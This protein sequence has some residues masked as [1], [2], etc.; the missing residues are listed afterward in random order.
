MSW[1]NG[2]IGSLLAAEQVK[3]GRIGP[4]P[5]QALVA[6]ARHNQPAADQP[7]PREITLATPVTAWDTSQVL[8]TG[9]GRLY[10]VRVENMSADI[11]FAFF[12]DS[13]IAQVIAAVRVPAAITAGT[14]ASAS[15]AVFF[16]DPHVTGELF[17]TSLLCKIFKLDGT[18]NVAAVTQ[19]V[20][21]LVG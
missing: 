3:K 5:L 10:R 16:S 1:D 2:T 7:V 6:T 17:V 8:V 15:E 14:T 12:A 20:K 18:G 21:V 9:P 11:V 19:T 13:V 4:E